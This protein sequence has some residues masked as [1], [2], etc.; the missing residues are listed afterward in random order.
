MP[1]FMKTINAKIIFTLFTFIIGSNIIIYALTSSDFEEVISSS[2]KRNMITLSESIFKNL[3]MAMNTGDG[4]I[5]RATIAD[6]KKIDGIDDIK[7]FRSKTVEE[8][9]GKNKYT[10]PDSV[11]KNVFKSKHDE[12][13][14]VN[15]SLRLVKPLIANDICMACHSNAKKGQVLGVMDLSVSL[16]ETEKE[17]SESSITIALTMAGATIAIIIIFT[18]FF[19]RELL[20]PMSRMEELAESLTEGD[21]DLTKRLDINRG[22]ELSRVSHFIDEFIIKIQD[23]VNAAKKSSIH[24]VEAGQDLKQIASGIES[25]IQE[26][27]KKTKE[28]NHLVSTITT[29]L[30]ES[31]EAS[32]STANDLDKTGEVLN[33]MVEDLSGMINEIGKASENQVEMSQQLN[34]L[35]GEAEQVKDVL[36]VIKDIAEQTNLLALNAAIEAAR[37]GEHG[38][39]FAVVAD[40]VR[41]LAERTQK[42]L[43]EIDATINVVLQAVGNSSDM[44]GKSAA[45]MEKISKA[46]NQTQEKVEDT[47]VMMTDTTEKSHNSVQLVVAISHKTKVLVKSMD[48]VTDLAETNAKA[49]GNVSQIAHD[50]LSSAEDLKSKLDE[51]RS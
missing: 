15:N 44:M 46:A 5:I 3:R 9:Y 19:R 20:T 10:N 23:T 14:K 50:I 7:V 12:A 4:N 18:V 47:K 39:G 38:R 41:K 31:E 42:S 21:G 49:V 11:V 48:S 8:Y 17:I 24:S 28:S 33:N 29:D 30:N 2:T 27:N 22:D 40:E 34:D 1:D 45:E 43:S 16:R 25:A 26:Q 13:I 36:G 32:I 37:A 6:T 35:N 51:F